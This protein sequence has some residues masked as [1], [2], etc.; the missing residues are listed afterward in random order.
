MTCRRNLAIATLSVLFTLACATAQHPSAWVDPTPHRV[1]FLQVE[2][3]VRLEVLDWGG[4]GR[5]LVLLSGSGNTAHVFDDFA[6]KLTRLCH[7]YGIT[8]RGYGASSHPD[9]GYTA[10]RLAADVLAVLDS[11][12]LKSPVI[13]GHSLAGEE[14]STLASEHPHRVAGLI[15]MDALVDLTQDFTRFQELHNKL[16]RALT[17]PPPSVDDYKSFQ[18]YQN[19]QKRTVGFAFPES[20]LRAGFRAKPDGSMGSYGTPPTVREAI[21]QGATK[22]DYSRLRV[23]VLALVAMPKPLA[24]QYKYRPRNEAER[25]AIEQAYAAD[26]DL[27]KSAAA[28]LRRGDPDAHVVVLTGANHYVFLSSEADVLREVRRFLLRLQGL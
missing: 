24:D 27:A 20:E 12:Q 7:V 2:E 18:A 6:P 23:P 22:P 14:V 13:A 26:A 5:A 19:W 10:Q 21:H 11:L 15:Y 17:Q 16:P 9:S 28:D 1:Q 4:S 25:T 3:N 8:R